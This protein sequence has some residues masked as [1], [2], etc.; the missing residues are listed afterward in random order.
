M[1]L[2][3]PYRAEWQVLVARE[4]AVHRGPQ[5][6]EQVLEV[7]E[8]AQ[9]PLPAGEREGG[10]GAQTRESG[11]EAAGRQERQGKKGNERRGEGGTQ[12]QHTRPKNSRAHG[13]M[14]YVWKGYTNKKNHHPTGFSM[15]NNKH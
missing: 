10:A 2:R 3:L 14:K 15:T 12:M 11:L 9:P 13:V 6:T 8:A 7:W 1:L 4:A 5:L